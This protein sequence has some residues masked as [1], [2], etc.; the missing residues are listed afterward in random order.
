MENN[1]YLENL[2]IVGGIMILNKQGFDL[3]ADG[4]DQTVQLSEEGNQYPFAGYKVIL[5]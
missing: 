3:R 4:Y 2:S 5:N 1:A